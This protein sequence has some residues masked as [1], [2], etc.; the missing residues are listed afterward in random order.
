MN[1]TGGVISAFP[2]TWEELFE[3]KQ[4]LDMEALKSSP[5]F[6]TFLKHV[7]VKTILYRTS[8]SVSGISSACLITHILRSK[9]G[10][11]TTHHRLMFAI[12]VADMCSSFFLA[13]STILVPKEMAYFIPGAKGN[14]TSCTIQ[15]FVI[16]AVF[17]VV[18]LYNCSICFYYLAIIRYN[19]KD[20]YI[21]NKLEP[22]FHG[23]SIS[24]PF[25]L[26][27]I[28][29]FFKAYN[30]ANGGACFLEP[31][32]PP[33]CIGYEDGY[34]HPDFHIPCGRGNGTENPKLY[35]AVTSIGFIFVLILTPCVIIGTMLLMHASVSKIGN[36]VR[37]YSINALNL[38]DNNPPEEKGILGRVKQFFVPCLS[39]NNAAT[40]TRSNAPAT[41]HK[42]AV[43]VM[44]LGYA[45]AWGLVWIPYMIL[46]FVWRSHA[47]E[48]MIAITSPLQGFFN[49][50]VFMSPKVRREKSRRR[51]GKQ[52]LTWVQAF[53]KAYTSRGEERRATLTQL[54][55]TQLRESTLA[56]RSETR[57]QR[58]QRVFQKFVG[59]RTKTSAT[60]AGAVGAEEL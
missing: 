45:L 47:T 35:R 11:S 33:H 8:G 39:G 38:N 19:K 56:T 34:E 40:T 57:C 14:T 23:V 15:G 9:K 22:W 48:K 28:L 32:K 20:D 29:L 10:L 3:Y 55:V 50:L 59:S 27:I 54:R 31:S 4:P 51:R 2:D 44:A 53:V 43:L 42:R 37:R 58:Y 36:K 6:A 13:L 52:N 25:M 46:R 26:N 21:R 17:I 49:F 12:S 18:A 7:K 16:S 41:S 30:E 60:Q 24:I 5:V 1:T